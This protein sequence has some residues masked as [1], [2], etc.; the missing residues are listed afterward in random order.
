VDDDLR[1]D[2]V[3][4]RRGAACLADAGHMLTS[5]RGDKG[6]L[7]DDE[8]AAHP[9][10]GDALGHAFQANYDQIVPAV[11]DAWAKLGSYLGEYSDGVAA[12]VDATVTAEDAARQRMS[13]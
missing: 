4:A 1:M 6:A 5:S 12:A 7:L 9:W 8:G 10:G 13:W 11:L 2:A 3:A